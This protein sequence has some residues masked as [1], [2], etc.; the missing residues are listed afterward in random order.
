VSDSAYEII[1]HRG[2]SARAPENTL[3]SLEAAMAAGAR[4][5]EFDV[6]VAACGTP[7]LFHDGML[8]RTTD[9]AGPLRKRTLAQLKRLDAG[10]WYSA[11][12]AGETIPSLEEAL[13]TLRGRVGRVYLEIKGFHELED[14]DHMVAV[15]RATGT[16]GEVVYISLNWTT[17]DRVRGQDPQAPVA[18]VI[19]HAERCDEAFERARGDAS[20]LLDFRAS[21]IL[22][23]PGLARRAKRQDSDMVVWTVNDPV[24]AGVLAELGVRRFTTNE[25]E[26]LLAWAARPEG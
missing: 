8:S 18:Y 23:D 10:S 12:F 24:E 9:G 19:D 26:A 14:V 5:V 2:F 15:V 16:S 4:A 11:E 21:L 7:V 3:A 13:T 22:D 1:A 6:Q 20:A 25:V 17:I